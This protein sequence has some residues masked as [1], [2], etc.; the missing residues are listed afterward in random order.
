VGFELSVSI[1]IGIGE[2]LGFRRQHRSLEVVAKS[3]DSVEY[4][5][6]MMHG[7]GLRKFGQFIG[8]IQQELVDVLLEGRKASALREALR[9]IIQ[10][11]KD[12]PCLDHLDQ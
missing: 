10:C 5:R 9:T 1:A 2:I 6:G 3:R 8:A 12:K 4:L 11:H 7:D